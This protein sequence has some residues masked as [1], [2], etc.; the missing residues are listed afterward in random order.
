[1]RI[2]LEERDLWVIDGS[3]KSD[4]AEIFMK[5]RKAFRMYCCLCDHNRWSLLGSRDGK[6]SLGDSCRN[7]PAVVCSQSP[8]SCEALIHDFEECS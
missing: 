2:L 4:D 1:M 8:F 7:L 3:V 5:N 6:E